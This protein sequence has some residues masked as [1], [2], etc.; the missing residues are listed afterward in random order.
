MLV[1]FLVPFN[2]EKKLENH[3]DCS[4]SSPRSILLP[5]LTENPSP[6]PILP[7][8]PGRPH[9]YRLDIITHGVQHERAVVILVIMRPEP[10]GAV[11]LPTSSQGRSVEVVDDGAV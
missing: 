4:S 11:T 2:T 5:F 7:V 1:L 9:A 8:R 3:G 10:R 6:N